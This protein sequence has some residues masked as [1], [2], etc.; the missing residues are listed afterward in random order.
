MKEK[1]NTWRQKLTAKDNALII[2]NNSII[3][4][5]LPYIN[6]KVRVE[7]EWAIMTTCKS[8]ESVKYH[9]NIVYIV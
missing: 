6:T 8:L 3:S 5:K 7:N 1:R 4:C 9:N 2:A